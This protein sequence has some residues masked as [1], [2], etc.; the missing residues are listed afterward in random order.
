MTKEVFYCGFN[1][2]K[3]VPSSSDSDTLTCLTIL[4]KNKSEV[5]VGDVAICWNYLVV[6]DNKGITK[7]GLVNNK[8]TLERLDNP[9]GGDSV[10]Q[11]SATPRYI[12]SVTSSGQ[13]WTNEEGKVSISQLNVVRF[14]LLSYAGMEK[15]CGKQ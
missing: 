6:A 5:E 15:S 10:I 11:T 2:F 14:I 9:P 12:L 8:P 13:C 3:Q 1:G 7:Y 4:N